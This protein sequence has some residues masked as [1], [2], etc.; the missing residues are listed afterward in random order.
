MV[1]Q[2][3]NDVFG[4]MPEL[5]SSSPGRLQFLGDHTD[6]NLGLTVSAASSQRI[7]IGFLRDSTSTGFSIHS[8]LKGDSGTVDFT[9]LSPRGRWFDYAIG[10]TSRIKDTGY[11]LSGFKAFVDS[12]IP[13]GG[14]MSSSAAFTVAFLAGVHSLFGRSRKDG[15]LIED[16]RWVDNVFL[17]V[18]TGALDQLSVV[19]SRS[20]HMLYL[21]CRTNEFESIPLDLVSN[22]IELIVF[23]TGISHDLAMESGYRDRR[24][25]CEQ[26]VQ[27]L[28]SEASSSW[29][30]IRDIPYKEFQKYKSIL[31]L[32]YS[33]RVE[34]VLSENKRCLTAISA[35]RKGNFETLGHLMNETHHS[36]RTLFN[37]TCVELDYIWDRLSDFKSVYG[38]KLMGA[39]WGG[40]ILAMVDQGAVNN[41]ADRVCSDYNKEFS[42]DI[43]L[44]HTMLGEHARVDKC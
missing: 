44:Y 34:H 39:G 10:A 24:S 20:G 5:V 18:P 41:I 42:N 2:R 36:C 4:I 23:D 21:D 16:A 31:P 1:F 14:G 35:I 37:N 17:N 11:Q 26:A 40:V 30:T 12:D 43:S 13:V 7:Y 25:Q 3:L 32:E 33:N 22:N 19:S 29:E 6:Y 27:M 15:Q 38:A 9:D 8:K 28:A